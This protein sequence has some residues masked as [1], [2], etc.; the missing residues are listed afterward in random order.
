MIADRVANSDAINATNIWALFGSLL[1]S[2][3]SPL[4]VVFDDMPPDGDILNLI[5]T[6]KRTL[7]LFTSV[8]APS[9]QF[10]GYSINVGE[11]EPLEL[12]EMVTSRLPDATD[13]ERL[14]LARALGGRPLAI[15]HSCSYI[16]ETGFTVGDYCEALAEQPAET[17]EAAGER[18]GTTLTKIYQLT[19]QQLNSSLDS[20]R[21][22]DL[23]IF[24]SPGLIN[25]DV[26]IEAWVEE[27]D[28]PSS[29]PLVA[30]SSEGVS[31]D[32]VDKEYMRSASLWC[33]TWPGAETLEPTRFPRISSLSRVKLNA[34]LRRLEAFGLVRSDKDLLTVHQ[35]T[36]AILRA[37]RED[38]ADSIFERLK[39]TVYD[40]LKAENWEAGNALSISR[41]RWAPHLRETVVRA[42]RDPVS[43]IKGPTDE[44]VRLATLAVMMMRAHRQ[45]GS[46]LVRDIYDEIALLFTAIDV[47]LGYMK[48]EVPGKEV[49]QKA[50]WDLRTEIFESL[51]MAR[52]FDHSVDSYPNKGQAPT[53]RQAWHANSFRL[54]HHTEWELS[55]HYVNTA[56][57]KKHADSARKAAM[58][59]ISGVRKFSAEVAVALASV[60]YDQAKWMEAVNEL[61]YAYSSYLKVAA[62]IEHI[63]GAMDAARRLS[64]VHL[65]AGRLDDAEAWLQ[66]AV[67]EVYVPRCATNFNGKPSPFRLHDVPFDVQFSQ[68]NVELELTRAALEWDG[69]EANLEP[70][71]IA[72]FINPRLEEAGRALT[73]LQDIAALRLVPEFKVY[74]FRLK[75]LGG[76]R[77]EF[78]LKSL[79]SEFESNAL[80]YQSDLLK[81]QMTVFATSGLAVYLTVDEQELASLL[82]DQPEEAVRYVMQMRD[83][84]S[85]MVDGIYEMAQRMRGYHHNPYWY[86]R[87]LCSAVMLG[88]AA[89]RNSSW[90]GKVRN[91]LDQ[92]AS[93]I[94]RPDWIEKV[95]GFGYTNLGMWLLGY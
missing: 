58:A 14:Q 88:S 9:S 4:V 48:G 45:L 57:R 6:P 94:D 49:L 65:R 37:L 20:L 92:A 82:T 12:L 10:H 81:L 15:E 60:Y 2:E 27:L 25:A 51:I 42:T 35:L 93:A 8:Q 36:R 90:L 13:E 40:T 80:V 1:D 59:P 17:L 50:Y 78:L 54:K 66:R 34:A 73:V 3:A 39:R 46:V 18:F 19:L 75:A 77:D 7:L 72:Q 84:R 44:L 83:S 61:E 79:A 95:D 62:N 55:H 11:L 52:G 38:Q 64:R 32:E 70:E 28:L 74:V 63:R 47:R 86:A 21:A 41:I 89:G 85:E 30:P 69:S 87:G 56:A 23:I 24:T 16:R 29:A 31:M 91:E 33:L 5:Q 53:P 76:E 71:M 67:S 43:L 68:A 22:L 26:L